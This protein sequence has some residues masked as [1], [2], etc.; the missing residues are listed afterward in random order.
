MAEQ[1]AIEGDADPQWHDSEQ[2][3]A[4]I[5]PHMVAQL[6]QWQGVH[7]HT[8]DGRQMGATH[9]PWHLCSGSEEMTVVFG[10]GS[11]SA[12]SRTG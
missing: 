2:I 12:A 10:H 5:N 11:C 6:S 3:N 1:V 7:A 8:D 9:W 4:R